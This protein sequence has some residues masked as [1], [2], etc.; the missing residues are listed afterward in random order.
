MRS[1]KLVTSVY[2]F[3]TYILTYDSGVD[4]S[5]NAVFIAAIEFDLIEYIATDVS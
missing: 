1:L 5:L 2:R 4:W 3:D